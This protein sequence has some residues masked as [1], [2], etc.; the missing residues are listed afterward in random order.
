MNG[1]YL[2]VAWVERSETRVSL[3]LNPGY[4]LFATRNFK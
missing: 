3:S 4:I 1:T 2:N